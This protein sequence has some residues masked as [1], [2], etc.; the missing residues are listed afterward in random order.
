MVKA[1]PATFPARY[2]AIFV[3]HL[4]V[5]VDALLRSAGIEPAALYGAEGLLTLPQVEALVECATERTGRPDLGFDAGRLIKLSSHDIL[6]YAIISSPTLDYA[7][8]LACAPLPAHH[9]HLYDAVF[10]R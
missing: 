1:P 7:L 2:Y 8:R 10:A 9:P 5:D 4:G 3:D 6:G